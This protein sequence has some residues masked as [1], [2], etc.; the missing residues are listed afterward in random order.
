MVN[1]SPQSSFY[2]QNADKLKHKVHDCGN[3]LVHHLLPLGMF[4]HTALS[5]RTIYPPGFWLDQNNT[6]L[7]GLNSPSLDLQ[8]IVV[9]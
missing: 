3:F 2:I 8:L 9:S 7:V 4:R 6:A 1:I 5:S